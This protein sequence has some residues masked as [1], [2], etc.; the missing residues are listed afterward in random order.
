MQI[1][2]LPRPEAGVVQRRENGDGALEQFC[3]LRC[4]PL[5]ILLAGIEIHQQLSGIGVAPGRW[6][7]ASDQATHDLSGER[8]DRGQADLGEQSQGVDLSQQLAKRMLHG[9]TQLRIVLDDVEQKCQ[10]PEF[11]A[12]TVFFAGPTDNLHEGGSPGVEGRR[13]AEVPQESSRLRRSHGWYRKRTDGGLRGKLLP[14][15]FGR[16]HRRGARLAQEDERPLSVARRPGWD[17]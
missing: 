1:A 7:H 14:R 16:T 17:Q 5:H 13:L 11:A 12:A 8:M 10:L 4:E 6:E 9:G 2:Q 3:R 15:A